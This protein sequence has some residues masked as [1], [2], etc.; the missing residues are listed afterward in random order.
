MFALSIDG[1]EPVAVIV[2]NSFAEAWGFVRAELGGMERVTPVRAYGLAQ[3][4]VPLHYAKPEHAA[5][6][7]LVVD[8]VVQ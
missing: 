5:D 1:N 6:G 4:G 2:A 7:D 8:P 3:M